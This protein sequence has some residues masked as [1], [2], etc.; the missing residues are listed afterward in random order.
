MIVKGTAGPL[1]VL[2]EPYWDQ[3][4]GTGI[5][6]EYEG[7]REAIVGMFTDAR[8]LPNAQSVEIRRGQGP[9]YVLSI[10]LANLE[11]L[12]EEAPELK[13]SVRTEILQ[14]D[15]WQ[16]PTIISALSTQTI[17]T[18]A[19]FRAKVTDAADTGDFAD[20][21]LDFPTDPLNALGLSIVGELQRGAT[22]YEDETTAIS[23]ARVVSPFYS[24]PMAI[25]TAKLVYT[26]SQLPIPANYPAEVP[27]STTLTPISG[28]NWGWRLRTQESEWTGGKISQSFEFILAAWSSFLYSQAPAGNWSFNA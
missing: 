26:T 11:G 3:T 23:I 15:I 5:R 6:R 27:D 1:L 8:T 24:L 2:E 9:K 21:T 12:E 4:G 22:H 18:R 25:Y 16:H 28:A 14:K 19:N 10:K 7:T 17:A 13:V 20:F